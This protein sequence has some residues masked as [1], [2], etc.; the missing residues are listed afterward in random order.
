MTTTKTN[1]LRVLLIGATGVVGREVLR[2]ALL[3]ARISQVVALTRRPLPAQ[4]KLENHLP[5]FSRLPSDASWW[6]VDAVI[7]TLGTTIKLAG[8]RSAFAA[9][10]RDLPVSVARLARKF[11]ATRFALNSS[12]GASLAGSFYL[13]TKAEAEA[14]IRELAFPSYTIVRPSLIDADR[15]DSRPAEAFA[16][17]F[18]HACRPLI[19]KRYRAVKPESIAHALLEG[20]LQDKGGEHIIES[21]QLQT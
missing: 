13:R 20:V 5:D 2:L 8:S 19:P 21:D 11:G 17:F 6:Q 18:A 1:S 10:D 14:G 3:D 9:V 7:C 4:E 16:L 12:L 15:T